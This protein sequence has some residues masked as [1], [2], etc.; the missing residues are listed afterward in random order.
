MRNY[1]LLYTALQ[2]PFR[3][4]ETFHVNYHHQPGPHAPKKIRFYKKPA[5]YNIK[6]L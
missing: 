2:L 5:T 6:Y 4:S 3:F 1:Q